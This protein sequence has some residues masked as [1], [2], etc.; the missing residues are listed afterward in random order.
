[1]DPEIVERLNEQLRE[2]FEILSEQNAMMAA[3]MKSMKD[4]TAASDKST[5]ASAKAT[6]AT[7]ELTESTEELTKKEEAYARAEKER[8]EAVQEAT[9]RI[10]KAMGTVANGFLSLGSVVMDSTQS[11]SK[12]NGIIGSAGDAALDLGKNFGVLGTVIGGIVKASTMLMQ[13]QLKQSDA[14][15]KFNDQ[16]S[17]MGA[18]NAF[19]TDTILEMAHKVGLTSLELDKLM[20]PIKSMGS[21]FHALGNGAADSTLKFAKMAEVGEE[22]RNEFRRLGFNDEERLQAQADFVTTMSAGGIAIRTMAKDAGFLQKASTEYV[23]NLIVLSDITGQSIEQQQK[24]QQVA[25]A[26][27]QF[28]AYSNRMNRKIRDA[29]ERG[30]SAEVKRLTAELTQ[31]KDAVTIAQN[32]GGAEMAAQQAQ[33]IMQGFSTINPGALA[34]TGNRSVLEKTGRDVRAGDYDAEKAGA[35]QERL[36]ENISTAADKFAIP[37]SVSPEFSGTL[38]VDV[39]I[40]Q[41]VGELFGKNSEEIAKDTAARVKANEEGKGASAEDGRQQAR[42]FLVESERTLR[43]GFDKLSATIGFTGAALIGLAGAAG[44]AGLALAAR[45]AL[46]KLAGGAAATTAA[47]AAGAG[48]AGAGAAGAGAAG[49]GA[50]GAGAAGAGAA[51][52]GAAGAGAAG[53]GGAAAAGKGAQLLK[54]AKGAAIVAGGAYVI[55]AGFGAAGVG[56]D[57][58]SKTIQSQDDKNWERASTWEKTQSSLARGI[59]H[60]GRFM[61]MDNL[62]NQAQ[63]DRVKS[64]TEYLDKKLSAVK[65]ESKDAAKASAATADG[66]FADAFGKHVEKFGEIVNKLGSPNKGMSSSVAT[67]FG[68]N[69]ESF[70]K[71]I[72]AFAKTVTA[73]AKTVQAFATITGTFAKAVKMFADQNKS[74]N[75]M[76]S[77][78]SKVKGKSSGLLGTPME[79]DNELDVVDY[80]ER[81]KTSLADA[82]LSTDSLREAEMKRHRFTEESMMQFRRSLTDASKILNKIAGVDEEETDDSS[83]SNSGGGD[84]SS[85]DSNNSNNSSNSS[86]NSSS[87]DDNGG[88]ASVSGSAS[89][90]MEYFQSQGWSKQQAAGIVGN[91]QAESG[92]D[93]DT[94][95]IAKND[96]GPGKHSYGIAQ[97]NKGRFE[98]LKKF[99]KKRGTTWED[100]DTQLAFVQHELEGSEGKA[101]KL[102]GRTK[103]AESAAKVIDEYYE[104]STGEH[105]GKRIKYARAL[106][107]AS[108]GQQEG[109]AKSSKGMTTI[110]AQGKSATVAAEPAP[111]FQSLLDAMTKSGYKI[112]SLGGYSDRNVAGTGTKSAHSRGWAIDVNPSK[113][114]HTRGKLKT[115]MPKSVVNHA[116]SIGLGWGGD[117]NSS[118]DAMHYSA[119][120]NEGGY[121]K[122]RKGGIFDGPDSGYPVE[123]HGSEMITPLTQDS[124]LAKLAKTP[125]ETPEISNAISLP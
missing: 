40:M 116:R 10:N 52:A 114:P 59:E 24:Q 25:M 74:I 31:A 93:L 36:V 53:A 85:N 21:A 117:W 79:D 29:D 26:N 4:L 83:S 5:T 28:M 121:L 33:Y 19:S 63:A 13:Y 38:G 39:G 109:D 71:L 20:Q 16:I 72:I 1:M 104:R 32:V 3:Q 27:M 91:L 43:T 46:G 119:Q 34:L 76:G 62:A 60:I 97:W 115:D 44:L 6:K 95:S 11:F 49:A 105:I 106:A 22:V 41:R 17:K 75:A 96:A 37:L 118:K 73:F 67:S 18:A 86:N 35:A 90:A 65:P 113:N 14:L 94:T 8:Q 92:E 78:N 82:A 51:G 55:D 50:A 69:I 12:Y 107:A 122:A 102:L 9:D 108:S 15:L 2:M 99:A 123:M 58:D 110:Q 56:K 45:G 103:D 23:K 30:D 70:G 48:A 7:K 66:K 42:D 125:A 84:S 54:A 89:R 124:V 120:E 57:L 98:N 88:G 100:F 47:T 111:K 68:K 87:S 77:I 112:R 81:L 101:G 61:F 80:I 64:E